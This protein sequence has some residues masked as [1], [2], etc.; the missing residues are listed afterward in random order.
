MA[1]VMT[2]T[3]PVPADRLGFTLM[4]E[5]IFLDL[6]RDIAGRNSLLNDP[7]LAARELALYRQAGGTTL[8]DQTTGGLRGHDHDITPTAHALAVRDVARRT[9]LQVVLGAGWYREPY[10]ERRLWR[11]KTDQIAEELVRDVTAGLDG[12][13]VRAGLLGEIGSH[14]TWISPVEERVFRAVA[15]A[16][17]RTGVS[18]ATHAL[19]SP[20]G[21]D[22]LAILE[23][24]GVDPRRVVVGH[25]HSYPVPEYHAA[26]ARRGAFVSFDRLGYVQ[27]YEHERMLEGIRRLVE[28]G[29]VG[30]VVLSQDV[31]WRTDYVAYGGR[32]YAF[33]P[34]GLREELRALGIGDEPFHRMTVDNPRRALTGEA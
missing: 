32:G 19:N 16:H 17:R 18:I 5:H 29:L 4:H 2:V 33:V 26:L 7:E 28:A 21:L 3:G 12:T 30:H 14:F 24:E 10:Y 23:E 27:P 1:T 22:Q 11:M 25:A 31:C 6:T 20:V 9:G 15:R 34:T 13:D 8:V